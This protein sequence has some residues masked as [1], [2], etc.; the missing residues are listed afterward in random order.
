MFELFKTR[1]IGTNF[2]FSAYL[3]RKSDERNRMA[4]PEI[5]VME[6][7]RRIF[8]R[9]SDMVVTSGVILFDDGFKTWSVAPVGLSIVWSPTI[10]AVKA[11]QQPIIK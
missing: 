5:F 8:M 7:M 2:T 3:R 4:P 9:L 6:Q 10:R 1:C 11:N